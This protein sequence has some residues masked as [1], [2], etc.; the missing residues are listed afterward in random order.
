[1]PSKSRGQFSKREVQ[2]KA[3]SKGFNPGSYPKGDYRQGMPK[4]MMNLK[5]MKQ[6]FK[7]IS[8]LD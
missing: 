8:S 5:S 6:N 2:R 7:T 3:L 1:M 4:K